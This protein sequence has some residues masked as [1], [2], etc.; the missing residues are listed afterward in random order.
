MSLRLDAG[1]FYGATAKALTTSGFRFTEK[2]YD[3]NLRLPR[4]SHELAHFCFVL[5]GSYEE[6][7]GQINHE[8]LPATLI[9][10]PPD[11]SHAEAHK[12]SGRHFLIEIDAAR[13]AHLGEYGKLPAESSAVHDNVSAWLAMKLYREFRNPDQ[14]SRLAIEG[15]ALELMAETARSAVKTGESHPPA[16]LRQA[17]EIL[18]TAFVEP[19]ALDEIARQVGV[20][21]VHLARVFRKFER[22]TL[23]DYVRQLRITYARQQ[24]LYSRKPLVEIALAAGFADQ[25]HFSR[26][27]KRVTGMT[28]T[29]FRALLDRG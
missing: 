17:K 9:F 28:P 26:S 1:N 10:Y 11:V 15:V 22:C 18:Q 5:A 29:E 21:P 13:F 4:H 8:R 7:V 16:C 6:Q 23:G 2:T 20:H 12:A 14:F 27:F 19:P 3:S 25:T 24:M